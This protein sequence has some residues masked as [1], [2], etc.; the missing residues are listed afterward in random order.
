MLI[1]EAENFGIS[2][3]HQLRGRIGRGSHASWCLFHTAQPEDSDSYRRLQGVAATTDG[4]ALAEL[5]LATR[6]EGDLV[7]ADQSGRSTH[8]RLLDVVHDE[9]LIEAAKTEAEHIVQTDP[10]L[11]RRLSE[12]YSS[13]EREFLGKG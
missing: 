13:T 4:F 7:G 2:Q 8:I 6:S 3:L 12:G 1:R 5:D 11:A 9:P 10:G